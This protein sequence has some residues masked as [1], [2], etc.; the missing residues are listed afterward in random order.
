MG[1]MDKINFWKKK[2]SYEPSNDINDLS[3][4]DPFSQNKYD[5]DF[6]SDPFSQNREMGMQRRDYPISSNQ[7]TFNMQKP[8]EMREKPMIPQSNGNMDLLNKNI[9]IISSKLDTLK[10]ELDSMNQR[11]IGIEAASRKN[12]K[13]PV[14]RYQW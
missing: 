11:L 12:E 1:I 14:R 4:H 2:D 3:E 9:E 7:D 13:E 5:D 8:F 6:G 10:A